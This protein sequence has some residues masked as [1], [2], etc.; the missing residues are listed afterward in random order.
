MAVSNDGREMF[1]AMSSAGCDMNTAPT[2]TISSNAAMRINLLVPS[3]MYLPI[4]SGRLR[5]LFFK[6]MTPATKSCM[7]PMNM[8]PSVIHRKATGPYAAPSKAPKMGP[9]PAMLSNWMRK[10]LHL[11]RGI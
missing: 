6:D 2:R 9:S 4:I 3:P 1:A 10:I 5:P 7:A 8:P 11:G